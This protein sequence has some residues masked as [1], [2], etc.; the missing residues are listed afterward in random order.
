[1]S[2][3]G[4]DEVARK[5]RQQG[6]D[7]GIAHKRDFRDFPVVVP[8]KAEV[9][10][11]AIDAVPAWEGLRTDDQPLELAVCFDVSIR[12]AGE[13]GKSSTE[14][15]PLG[16]AI[17]TPLSLSMSCS[18][19]SVVFF[20]LLTTQK[21]RTHPSLH[22]PNPPSPLTPLSSSPPYGQINFA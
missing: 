14:R 17:S 20:V 9:G 2:H 21:L 7:V 11:E 1:V 15:G 13:V 12:V 18:I 10:K 19:M 6:E 8:N 3:F 5:F 22:L 4:T 16:R